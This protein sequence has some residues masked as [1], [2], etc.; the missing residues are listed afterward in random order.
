[1]LTAAFLINRTP[2]PVLGNKSP[3][4][5][6]YNVHVDYPLLKV[7]HCLA[8]ASTYSA[9][10]TKSDPR[11]RICVFLGYPVGMK[12][13]KLYDLQTKQF[14]VSRDVTFHETIF[15]F[16]SISPLDH[17]VD[18]FPDLVLPS[19]APDLNTSGSFPSV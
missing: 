7:F 14:F 15:P 4:E 9:H 8:F 16:H 12:G 10:R 13:Y 18:P 11:A 17:L 3:F 5:L 1:M 6:L 2:T 19:P